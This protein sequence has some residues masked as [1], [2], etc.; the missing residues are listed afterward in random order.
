[1]GTFNGGNRAFLAAV[2]LGLG[3]G[4]GLAQ[5]PSPGECPQPRFT[6]KAP[7]SY[8][9]Q[10]NP[11]PATPDNIAKGESIFNGNPN[12]VSCM[13][14]HGAKG[15]GKGKLADLFD[16]RPRNF[17]CAD[18]IKGIPDGHLFWIVRFGSPE[19]SMPPHKRLSDE[20]IWQVVHY[21]RTLA[22]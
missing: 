6:G 7:D 17:S 4:Q 20:Q 8:Y 9:N 15:D 12:R 13:T 5:S 21:I 1:M 18:T 2:L 3:S 14:C 10:A 11:L 19:T 22:N 16:P